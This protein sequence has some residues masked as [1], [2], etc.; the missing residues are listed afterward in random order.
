MRNFACKLD[1]VGFNG[2]SHVTQ[3]GLSDSSSGV[4]VNQ[5]KELAK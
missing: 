5:I 1:L 4:T 3:N 2:A